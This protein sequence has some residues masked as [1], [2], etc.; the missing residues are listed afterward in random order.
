MKYK[1]IILAGGNGYLGKVLANYYKDKA[2][3]V[4]ILSRHEKQAEQMLNA[5]RQEEKSI[6]KDLQKNK[7][8]NG[9]TPDKDW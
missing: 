2:G 3:E 7:T 9:N 1:K 6:Q 8:K 5:L 4:V